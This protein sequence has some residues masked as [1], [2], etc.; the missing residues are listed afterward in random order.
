MSFY[1]QKVGQSIGDINLFNTTQGSIQQISE[2]VR[3]GTTFDKLTLFTMSYPLVS[4]SIA[5]SPKDRE[6]SN[7]KQLNA[8]FA[9]TLKHDLKTSFLQLNG[10]ES[11]YSGQSHSEEKLESLL[12]LSEE[13][14]QPKTGKQ[15]KSSG[16]KK[17]KDHC[18]LS[19]LEIQNVQIVKMASLLS[20]TIS[21][22][23]RYGNT[24]T[25]KGSLHLSCY[26]NIAPQT[27][28]KD[29]LDLLCRE[30]DFQFE[31]RLEIFDE[32]AKNNPAQVNPFDLNTDNMTRIEGFNLLMPRRV[33][34]G[35][36]KS[37]NKAVAGTLKEK[38]IFNDYLLFFESEKDS[39]RRLHD[40]LGVQPILPY[41]S[42][43]KVDQAE[44][45]K[46]LLKNMSKAQVL[47]A[48]KQI[49]SQ[50]DQNKSAN[51][52]EILV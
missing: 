23:P 12:N 19:E 45:D 20:S 29:L 18:P 52:K 27:N 30:I 1:S 36:K 2:Q 9:E 8:Q 14:Q 6:V 51:G 3:N 21:D 28:L 24:F 42:L 44:I 13:D 10:S 32:E 7:F 4:L 37:D 41:N 34:F 49:I 17:V 22:K 40:S 43:E 38:L 47:K 33:F 48:S 35:L 31:S 16:P 26:L 15:Q 50:G 46:K 25:F 39:Q 11:L 5:F